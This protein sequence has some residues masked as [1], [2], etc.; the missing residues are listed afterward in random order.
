MSAVCLNLGLKNPVMLT[1]EFR[2]NRSAA[3]YTI[4][5]AFAEIVVNFAVIFCDMTF[6][7]SLAGFLTVA[8]S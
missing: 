6:A 7:A 1:G 5:F 3:V 8:H 4:L 2:I